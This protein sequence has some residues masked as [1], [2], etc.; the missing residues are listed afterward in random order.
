MAISGPR[1]KQVV[2]N[3]EK[4]GTHQVPQRW[5]RKETTMKGGFEEQIKGQLRPDGSRCCPNHQMP[6]HR[7]PGE[8][9]E[10]RMVLPL[11]GPRTHVQGMPQKDQQTPTLLESTG[12]NDPTNHHH[13]QC[14]SGDHPNQNR[15]RKG[16]PTC[17]RTQRVERRCPRQGFKQSLHRTRG[18]LNCSTSTT[19]SRAK[20]P[21]RLYH[22]IQKINVPFTV[23][24][25]RSMVEK[26]LL[27]SGMMD[28]F[29]D[30]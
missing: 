30:H 28:N 26:A 10:G 19:W 9:K 8:T 2:C 21:N 3:Q 13:V 7:A 18:F 25:T 23:C 20:E 14:R 5:K 16:Q 27:D 4:P 11:R 29:I 17:G 15:Q 24:A 12:G 6:P 1:R 22:N